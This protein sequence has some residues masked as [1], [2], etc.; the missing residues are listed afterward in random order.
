M[1]L[2]LYKK[3]NIVRHVALLVVFFFTLIAGTDVYAQESMSGG[4]YTLNGGFTVFTGSEEGGGYTLNSSGDP[5]STNGSGGAYTIQPTPYGVGAGSSGGVPTSENNNPAT[6]GQST[7][8]YTQTNSTS[9]APVKNEN[10]GK[11]QTEIPVFYPTSNIP[12]VQWIDSGS[13]VDLDFDGDSD[14]Y[15]E[16]YVP[17]DTHVG[18]VRP[19]GWQEFV[20]DVQHYFDDS[21]PSLL[22]IYSNNFSPI[23][24]IP[25]I[26]FLLL[27]LF[28]PVI[29]STGRYVVSRV[30]LAIALDYLIALHKSLPLTSVLVVQDQKKNIVSPT[31]SPSKNNK[32]YIGLVQVGILILGVILIQSLG[33]ESALLVL[34]ILAILLFRLHIRKRA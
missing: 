30:P 24:D 6:G 15:N 4:G 22:K 29:K 26:I 19:D 5:I 7:G 11:V 14:I 9:A 1:N 8:G 32:F 17:G 18:M 31:K 12:G 2:Y 16:T 10:P 33:S 25:L 28:V 27:A 20:Y 23:R 3:N 34:E 13:G 21:V